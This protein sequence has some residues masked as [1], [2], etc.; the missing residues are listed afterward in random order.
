MVRVFLILIMFI[1]YLESEALAPNSINIEKNC[2]ACHTK[3]KIPS[4]LIYRRYLT[5]YSTHKTIRKVIF[6]Y[7]KNPKKENSIMPK[8]FFLKFPPKKLL[9]IND[10][11][12]IEAIDTYLDHLDVK[13]KL[14]LP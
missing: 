13:K 2:I 14:V 4:E 8:Q 6:E 9:D 7:L 3:Q 5:K 1:G 12:L 11:L 10:S